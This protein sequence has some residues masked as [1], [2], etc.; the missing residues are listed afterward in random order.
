[1][2]GVW[3]LNHSSIHSLTHTCTHAHTWHTVNPLAV[4][5][6]RLLRL[7]LLLVVH[8]PQHIDRPGHTDQLLLPLLLLRRCPCSCCCPI[9]GAAANQLESRRRR[10]LLPSGSCC[11]AAV[12]QGSCCSRRQVSLV[13]CRAWAVEQQTGITA[14][15]RVLQ[16]M[17]AVDAQCRLT[18]LAYVP[19]QQTR[20]FTP[21]SSCCN[22]HSCVSQSSI[23][24]PLHSWESRWKD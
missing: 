3:T 5:A 23:D 4:G 10:L 13:L 6:R 15:A 24:R 18:T 14:S 8:K 2:T 7:L 16:G 12:R 20:A 19:T 22:N 1:M 21:A 11:C 17:F 9:G